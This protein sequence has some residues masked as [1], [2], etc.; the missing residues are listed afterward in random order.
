M[1]LKHP[2]PGV[3]TAS[4]LS[5]GG[6]QRRS[7]DAIMRRCGCGVVAVTDL[8][9]YL[10]RYHPDCAMPSL[11]ALGDEALT[12]QHYDALTLRLRRRYFP[13]LYP[14]GIPGFL[15]AAGL[16]RLFRRWHLPYAA[17]WGVP[18]AVLFETVEEMLRQ[19]IPV[20]LAVGGNFPCVWRKD[21]LPMRREG[22]GAAAVRAHYVT[23][24]AMDGDTLTVSSWGKKYTISR[25]AYSRYV[26]QSSSALVSNL[27][28]LRKTR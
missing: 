23:V 18:Q 2:Y 17:R 13:L 6:D 14:T 26:R 1:E 9:L 21:R 10:S 24:T 7:A 20:I 3:K 4:G 28:Y 11:T 27:L 8:L 22:G 25:R 15:L 12:P 16:N 5:F 19:D